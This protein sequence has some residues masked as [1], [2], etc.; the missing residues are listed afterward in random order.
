MCFLDC[1][2]ARV[3]GDAY[4]KRAK[5]T[6]SEG[7][8]HEKMNDEFNGTLQRLEIVVDQDD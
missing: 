2:R 5:G 7:I 8:G 4:N 3:S 1:Y 6:E